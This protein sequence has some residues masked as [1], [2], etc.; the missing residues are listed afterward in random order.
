PGE[1]LVIEDSPPGIESGSEAGMRCLGVTNTVSEK[2]LRDAGAEVV[3]ASLADWTVDAVRH[4][5][6]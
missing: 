3:T 6:G 2:Q 5:F 1:C 4:V